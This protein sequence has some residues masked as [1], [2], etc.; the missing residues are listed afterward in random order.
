MQTER[1]KLLKVVLE[2][3]TNNGGTLTT[4]GGDDCIPAPGVSQSRHV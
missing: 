1:D 2:V 4:S 3:D